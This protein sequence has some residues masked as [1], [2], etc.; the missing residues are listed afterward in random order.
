[1]KT[2]VLLLG[3]G[4]HAKVLI[5]CLH[6]LS[7]IEILGMLD[8]DPARV[9]QQVLGERVLGTEEIIGKY[10]PEEVCL[11]NAVGSSNLPT[12]RQKLFTKF[13]LLGYSFLSVIHPA[14]I[15][16]K[17][18]KLGEGIQL[19]VG[20]VVQPGCVV[21]DNVILNTG[22]SIDHDCQ[23]GNHVHLAPGVICSGHVSI[24][25]CSHI[26]VG[27]VIIQNISIGSYCL[28]GAGAVVINNFADNSKIVGVPAEK[29][30]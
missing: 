28:V 18:A 30:A 14:A 9:G 6:Q 27:S 4:G 16:S 5:D 7:D 22:A 24:G 2:K 10:T 29:Q 8:T 20:S 1:M 26:G 21:G 19:M 11:V 23:I 25:D 15:I 17:D 3:S 13:K 12:S